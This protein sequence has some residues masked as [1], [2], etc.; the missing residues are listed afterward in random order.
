MQRIFAENFTYIP[1]KTTAQTAM[2]LAHPTVTPKV[3]GSKLAVDIC[4]FRQNFLTFIATDF[5]FDSKPVQGPMQHLM[6]PIYNN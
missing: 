4:L 1:V 2:L 3:Q 6:P 5:S